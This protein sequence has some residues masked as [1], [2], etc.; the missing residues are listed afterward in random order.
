MLYTKA[1]KEAL[2]IYEHAVEKYNNTYQTMQETGSRLY[3]LRQ[4]SVKLI[5]EIELLLNSIA[6]K[7][8]EFE[9]TI[10]DIQAEQK[11]FRDAEEY[12]AEAMKAAVKSGISVAAGVAGGAAVASMAPSAA[13]WVATTF[14]TAS[15]GTAISTLSGAAATKAAL[16]WLGGGALSAGGAGVAGGQA[17][18]ALAGP[19]GWGITGVT[20]AASVV[21]L[22][23]K[24]KKIADEAIAEAKKITIAGAE[25]NESSAKIQHLIDETVMLMD[26]L[27]DMSRANT[28][29]RDA[30]YLE[31]S[32]KEQYR[33][34]A[35]VNSTLALAEMLNKTI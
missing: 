29:L 13:M 23:H 31:L 19:I 2:S 6:N 35:M 16:A 11:K 26:D 28:L 32:E 12:A 14:G 22:G 21:A 30:N 15:T 17:L 20:T 9:K 8:K 7:P 18:L 27:R 10:S 3:S 34:G 5:Q 24:N 25:V 33:L 4:D 1:K